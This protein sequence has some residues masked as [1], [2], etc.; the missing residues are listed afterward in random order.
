MPTQ[1]SPSY[2][3]DSIQTNG[4]Y[5]YHERIFVANLDSTISNTMVNNLR[6]QW[7]RDLEVAGA[8]CSSALR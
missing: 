1:T 5:V 8:N 4:S 7:G 6:F 2:N 3:N